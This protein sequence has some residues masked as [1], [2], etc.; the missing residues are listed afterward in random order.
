MHER[1]PRIMYNDHIFSSKSLLKKNQPFT[2]SEKK[3]QYLAVGAF[4]VKMGLSPVIMKDIFQDTEN[5]FTKEWQSSLRSNIYTVSF[6]SES[7]AN[8]GPEIWN[9][10][11]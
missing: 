8:L 5:Q 2:I 4:K 9:L 6:G 11:P 10:I 3:L 1:A 7:T